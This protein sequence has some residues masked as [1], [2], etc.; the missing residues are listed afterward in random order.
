MSTAVAISRNADQNLRREFE[1]LQKQKIRFNRA[2]LKLSPK[3]AQEWAERAVLVIETDESGNDR[4][5][6]QQ[7]LDC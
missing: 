6:E 7:E 2:V 1:D 4:D 5:T 3:E